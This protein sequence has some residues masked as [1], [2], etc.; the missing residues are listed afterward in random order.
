VSRKESTQTKCDRDLLPSLPV[1]SNVYIDADGNVTIEH[2]W[3][4][5]LPLAEALG[6]D[7]PFTTKEE[8]HTM[9][10]WVTEEE[11]NK[12]RECWGCSNKGSIATKKFSPTEISGIVICSGCRGRVGETTF[13]NY[14]KLITGEWFDFD[15]LDSDYEAEFYA[16]RA[17]YFDVRITDIDDRYHGWFDIETGNLIQVG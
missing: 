9:A 14:R 2:L 5:L 16:E 11:R 3:G 6:L 17:H 13:S 12:E 10:S 8:V 7:V 1:R 15:I 4:E